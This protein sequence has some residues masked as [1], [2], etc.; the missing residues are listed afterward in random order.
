M[1][2]FV[3][4]WISVYKLFLSFQ[5]ERQQR[6]IYS[7][8][9]LHDNLVLKDVLRQVLRGLHF[10]LSYH[11]HDSCI[12]YFLMMFGFCKFYTVEIWVI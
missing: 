10:E 9:L 11:S 4:N 8:Q 7:G 2:I 1:F 3:N 6:I 12:V 5:D